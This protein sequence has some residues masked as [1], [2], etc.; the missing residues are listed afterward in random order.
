[1]CRAYMTTYLPSYSNDELRVEIRNHIAHL[2]LNRPAALNA[3]S[4]SMLE[5]MTELFNQWAKDPDIKAVVAQGVGEKAFCAGGD[6]RGLYASVTQSGPDVHGRFFSVEYALNYQMHRFLKNTGKPYIALMD[7]IVMGGGMGISQ[8]ATLRI[9]GERTR[10]AMPETA[11]GL[12]PDV[13][14]SYFLSRAPGA[15]GLYIA[16]T[17]ST[18]RA[19]DALYAGLADVTM[20]RE[21]QQQFL[22][23]LD[24]LA[25][26]DATQ[27][28]A[29]AA[30]VA[31]AKSLSS[32]A[33]EAATGAAPSDL[34]GLRAAIDKHFSDKPSV[35]AIIDSLQT[36]TRPEFTPWALHSIKLLQKHS[37]TLLCVTHRQ[38]T[39]G[40]T[41]KLADCFRMELNLVYEAFLQKDLIEGIRAL[42]ID[43]DNSPKWNPATLAAVDPATVDRFFSEHWASDEH[44]LRD[45]EKKFG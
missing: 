33:P 15:T 28:S 34:A 12:F 30:I 31:L 45:L 9:V 39:A 21:A 44:P 32:N 35:Q 17:S 6:V 41:M 5:S 29:L 42:L 11:I 8:G 18:I 43:K 40:A 13:G 14:G 20:T 3:L 1:M 7:G 19:T 36:E 25:W 26:P 37:P 2:T 10:M 24:S 27:A 4:F 23:Q 16:L 38:I 22:A